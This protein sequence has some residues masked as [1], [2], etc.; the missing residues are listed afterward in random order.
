HPNGG[1]P[2]HRDFPQRIY[3]PPD[4]LRRIH[5]ERKGGGAE[6]GPVRLKVHGLGF[7]LFQASTP[8]SGY[9]LSPGTESCRD[10]IGVDVA[11][12]NSEVE[13]HELTPAPTKQRAVGSS[14]QFYVQGCSGLQLRAY[15]FARSSRPVCATLPWHV[16]SH[17]D[18]SPGWRLLYSK[19]KSLPVLNPV[20]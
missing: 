7:Y 2:H 10:N 1:E 11:S 9:L 18:R 14:E 3:R 5:R 17:L 12:Q 6:G 19:L 20:R 16:R 15:R 4:D 8:A 13:L